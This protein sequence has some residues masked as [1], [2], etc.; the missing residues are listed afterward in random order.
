MSGPEDDVRAIL[1]EQGRARRLD[2]KLRAERDPLDT[3]LLGER[4]SDSPALRREGSDT[5]INKLKALEERAQKLG[6]AVAY[7]KD[8]HGPGCS[9]NIAVEWSGGPIRYYLE[10]FTSK[11][12]LVREDALALLRE[13]GAA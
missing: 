10:G 1:Q 2:A 4:D 6:R 8:R 7:L 3:K 9:Y 13:G 11:D 12:G 5:G